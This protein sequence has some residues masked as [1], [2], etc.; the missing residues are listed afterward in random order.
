MIDF[1]GDTFGEEPPCFNQINL[2]KVTF[3]L[4]AMS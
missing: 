1:A 3:I 2:N 4:L